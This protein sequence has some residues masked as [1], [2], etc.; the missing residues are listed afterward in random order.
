MPKLLNNSKPTFKFI[1][2]SK[3]RYVIF[4]IQIL[5]Q[6][7]TLCEGHF[8]NFQGQKTRF[9]VLLKVVLEIFRSCLSIIFGLKRPVCG[10][11]FERSTLESKF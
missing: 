8:D 9:L 4:K 3:G 5:G 6:K 2:G 11:I 1:F 10:C 7:F